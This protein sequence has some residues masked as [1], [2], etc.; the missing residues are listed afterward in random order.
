MSQ[1]WAQSAKLRLTVILLDSLPSQA[2]SPENT[3]ARLSHIERLLNTDPAQAEF[4]ATELLRIIPGL[5]MALLFQGIARR[6]MGNSKAAIETLKPLSESCPDAP[7][8]HLQLGLAFQETGHKDAANDSIRRA[9]TVKTDFGDAWLA[10]GDLLTSMGDGKAADEAFAMYVRYSANEPRLHE[11]ARALK[12]NRLADAESLLR[13][14]L[15][16]Q[17]TDIVAICMLA[18]VVERSERTGEAEAYLKECLALAPAYKRARHN[19]AVVLLRQNKASEALQHTER[20]LAE[21]PDNLEIRKLTAA[22]LVR[23]REYERS[24]KICEEILHQYPD[25][26]TV[27]TSLGHMLKTVGR[28]EDSVDAYRKAI[29]QAPNF[30]EPYW[31]LANLKTQRFSEAELDAML[32]QLASPDL[33]DSDRLHFHFAIGKALEDSKEFAES[34][35]HYAEGNRIRLKNSPYDAEELADHVRRSKAFFTAELFSARASYGADAGDPIFV[36]GLPRSGSTLVEQILSSHSTVE[37]T[38]ELS[39]IAAMANSLDKWLTEPGQAKYP[40][41]L[42]G[43]EKE[44]FSE[45]GHAYIEQTR[46]HRQM[47]TPF[48]IDKKPNNFAHIGLLHL[49]LPR[50]RIIDVRRHPLACGFSLFKEHFAGGQNFSYSLEDIGIY[51]RHYVELMTHFDAVLPGRVHRV[52]YESLVDNTEVEV[53]LLL[54]YCGLAFEQ[55]CL[56]FHK[57]ERPVSTASSEQVRSPIFR[58]G[59]DHWR[60]YEPWLG[61][62]K[63]AVGVLADKYP[64]L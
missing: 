22:I 46:I 44:A 33:N 43:M 18:D 56:D 31:S 10:L 29:A 53:R 39:E 50:A 25:E 42:A 16:H 15:E 40:E 17:P 11:P 58:G 20:L 9:V 34:F 36:L 26:S 3:Q 28:R 21:D 32:V 60:H 63:T 14:H 64:E 4:Q 24:I 6:L 13:T 52:I 41:V 55:S 59:L 7:L 1:G 54:D 57:N 23:L 35:H 62:L 48:F 30:G 5:E 2:Q 19:Y 12:E 49:I 61:P 38:M 37:G 8:V 27:W 47:N 51:Y 45:M